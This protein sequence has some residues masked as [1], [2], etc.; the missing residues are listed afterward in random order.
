MMSSSRPHGKDSGNPRKQYDL[1]AVEEIP[2]DDYE[3][4]LNDD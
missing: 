1:E 3:T 4:Y 2:E